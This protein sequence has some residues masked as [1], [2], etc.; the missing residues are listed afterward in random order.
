MRGGQSAP[1]P[2]S[3]RM[4][5]KKSKPLTQSEIDKLVSRISLGG[6]FAKAKKQDGSIVYVL[7]KEL[8]SEDRAWMDFIYDEALAEGRQREL[9][10]MS[11]LFEFL[12]SAG[13]WTTEDEKQIEGTKTAIEELDKSL[14]SDDVSKSDKMR[15]Q[16][17]R[18]TMAAR[19]DE[20]EKTKSIHFS[21]SLEKYAEGERIRALVYCSTYKLDGYKFW[22][23][24]EDFLNE[25]D[26][27]LINN[28]TIE[29]SSMISL[30]TRTIREIA[31]SPIWRFKWAA[32]KDCDDLFGKPIIELT[33]NQESLVYWSQVYDAA[34]EA[35]ERP[36]DE[37][38]S[39][40]EE[41]DKWFEDQS[42]KRK[43]EQ[44]LESKNNKKSKISSKVAR[45]G[46]IGIR[47]QS[48]EDL[49]TIYELNDPMA[50]RFIAQ[51][52]ARIKKAGVISEQELRGDVD[53]RRMINSKDHVYSIKRG[54]D[55][56]ARR[57][58][59]KQFPG[60]TLEGRK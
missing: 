29:L 17:L 12:E 42:R 44:V 45:H 39:D 6:R 23:S 41:L 38:I 22:Q 33:R 59:D 4:D 35:Y 16:K 7:L 24:W 19:L 53:S 50:K 3:G 36:S 31:R 18:K 11:E 32:A 57:N 10:P 47:P 34:Y 14:D 55:G 52:N 27:T 37:I 28:I 15:I 40:D 58:V 51:Q 26:T 46:E 49:Q 25:V 9:V 5:M 20:M 60:G 56:F 48:E 8:T 21:S 30:D 2:L 1:L 43:A 54:P 13:T